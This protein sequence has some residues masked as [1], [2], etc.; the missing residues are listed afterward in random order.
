MGKISQYIAIARP[1]HWFKNVFMFPG[2]IFGILLTE[3]LPNNW[4]LLLVVGLMS[5]CLIASA[6]YVINEWLDRDF[7]K[8][9]PKKKS[10]PSVTGTIDG[11]FVY[12]E[13]ALLSICGLSLGALI[14]VNFLFFSFFLLVM[15]FL[16]NVPPFRTKEKIYLDVLSE[17]LNNPLRFLLGW[18]IVE[19]NYMPPSSILLAYWMG[20]AFL[21]GIKRFTEYRFIGDPVKAG[22]Y[23]RSFK[24]YTENTLL[25]SSF[26]YAL[27]SAFFLGVFLIKYR[28]EYLLILPF[29]SLLFAWYLSIGLSAN[30]T[31]QNPEK[32]YQEKSF[33]GYLGLLCGVF[34]FLS[35]VDL[36]WLQ[37]LLN[38]ALVTWKL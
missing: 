37:F 25:I 29:F 8:H 16:Y 7:D 2:I 21:M 22:L 4:V 32:L 24:Y 18:S 15:G 1:D 28:I 9:H 33:I 10:R 35:F 3:E 30:S 17:S 14:G 38:R 13:Y 23:R 36:P 26:F 11:R 20:G 5:T 27:S 12:L 34:V 31:A 6:N 19:F